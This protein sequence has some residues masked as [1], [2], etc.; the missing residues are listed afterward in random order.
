MFVCDL[1]EGD[2]FR[3][4]LLVREKQVRSNRNGARYLQLELDD[5]SG[6]V[7]GRHWN[8]TETE[9]GAFQTGDFLL[10]D[11][12]VQLFQGQ[13][14]LIIHSFRAVDPNTID[15][16]DFLPASDKDMEHLEGRLVEL[17]RGIRDP[18]L[19]AIAD[20]YLM[21]DEFMNR[22]RRVPAGI[23]NHHAYLGGL[24]EH[25]VCLMTVASRLTDLYPTLNHDLLRLGIFLHDSGKVRELI[26]DRVFGYSDD[27]QLVGHLIQGIE[28]LNEKLPLASEIFGEPIPD[29]LAM[30]LKHLIASHHGTYEFGS[31]KLPMTSEAIALHHLDNL[32]AKI[33][34]FDQKLRELAD[35]QARWT[36]YDS[37]LGRR[38][39]RGSHRGRSG[40]GDR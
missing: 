21:D 13:L 39:F 32:D 11:G 27:G 36:S 12:K 6:S 3:D 35:P 5:R 38:L 10:V 22:F 14:Q 15:I 30:Q 8:T 2:V 16:V 25:V 20:A 19:R 4:V 18:A 23:R 28:M 1:N 26:F 34:N 9:A 33:N 37:Q 17:L 29:D 24:L 7:S 31:P 40:S